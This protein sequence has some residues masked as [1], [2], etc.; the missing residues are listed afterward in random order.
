MLRIDG[1]H[2]LAAA[3]WC[4]RRT[5][6]SLIFEIIQIFIVKLLPL[7]ACLIIAVFLGGIHMNAAAQV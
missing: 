7:D 4:R 1:Y 6:Y 3:G 2:P 5:V